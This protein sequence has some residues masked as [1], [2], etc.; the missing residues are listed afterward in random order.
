[1]LKI[2]VFLRPSYSHHDTMS[3]F[4][5]PMFLVTSLLSILVFPLAA[6]SNLGCQCSSE[7]STKVGE[8]TGGEVMT[9]VDISGEL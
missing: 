9:S 4:M 1:M 5:F 8:R 7:A 2:S 3:F 6:E